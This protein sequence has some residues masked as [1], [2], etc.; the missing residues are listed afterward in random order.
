MAK[1]IVDVV[2][3]VRRDQPSTSQ[4]LSIPLGF[5]KTPSDDFMSQGSGGSL[6]RLR[7]PL[8]PDAQYSTVLT[9]FDLFDGLGPSTE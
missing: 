7:L 3:E 9:P 2:K 6:R 4:R 8:P 1:P 5:P